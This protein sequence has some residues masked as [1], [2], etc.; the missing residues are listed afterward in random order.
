M[1]L[2][3]TLWAFIGVETASVSAGVVEN[4]TRNVPIATLGGVILAGICYVLSSSAIMGM[5]PNK[6]LIASS[7]PFADAAL[8]LIHI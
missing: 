2:N 4:P 8:S 3:F 1:T 5:I 7:A 6:E